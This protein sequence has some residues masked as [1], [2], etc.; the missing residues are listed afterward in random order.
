MQTHIH[1]V[2]IA[3]RVEKEEKKENILSDVDKFSST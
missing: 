2:K 3:F 1:T